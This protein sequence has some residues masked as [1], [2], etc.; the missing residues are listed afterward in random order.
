MRAPRPEPAERGSTVPLILGFTI[1]ALLLVAGAVA[2]GQAFV[3]QRDL[4]DVCDGA[5][6]AAAGSAAD[7]N[8]AAVLGAGE[9]LTFT[10]V[11]AA[12]DAYL[13]RDPDRRDVHVSSTLSADGQT[14]NLVCAQTRD[15]PFGPAFGKGDGIRHVARS[16]ARAPLS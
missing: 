2:A 10:G 3:Q 16:A 9:A 14:L 5:A 15:I 12:V 6:A 11:Q 8:R 1:V 4:Q 7:L 13:S